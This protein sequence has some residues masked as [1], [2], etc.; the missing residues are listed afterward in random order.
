[1]SDI[2]IRVTGR[3]GRIT[4]TR[5]QALNA[6][7]YDMCRAIETA[8]DIWRDDDRVQLVVMD[9]EGDKAPLRGSF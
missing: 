8:L 2:D 5:P 3:A 4:L 7:T 6:M 1:M 9:A